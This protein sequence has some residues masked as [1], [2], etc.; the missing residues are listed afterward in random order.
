ME[1]SHLEPF[2]REPK[3]LMALLLL[4]ASLW[5][6]AKGVTASAVDCAL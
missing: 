4:E 2:R 5:Y 3:P 1:R 6:Y